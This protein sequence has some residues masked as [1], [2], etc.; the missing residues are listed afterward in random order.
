MNEHSHFILFSNYPAKH[1]KETV[2]EVIQEA[3]EEGFK[4]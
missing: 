3:C 4:E 2:Q 1:P